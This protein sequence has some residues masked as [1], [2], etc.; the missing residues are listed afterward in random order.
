MN[1]QIASFQRQRVD[2]M[3]ALGGTSFSA[4]DIA[5]TVARE[6]CFGDNDKLAVA[7]VKHQASV[8]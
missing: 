3:T 4:R 1:H 8:R 6:V 2:L 5:D 7:A